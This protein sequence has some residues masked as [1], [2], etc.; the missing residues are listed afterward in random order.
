MTFFPKALVRY[1]NLLY[2][3]EGPEEECQELSRRLLEHTR[4]FLTTRFLAKYLLLS[5]AV[6]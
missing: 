6:R 3:K 4:K 1:G 5:A 2:E